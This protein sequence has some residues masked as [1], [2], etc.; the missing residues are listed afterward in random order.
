MLINSI[1]RASLSVVEILPTPIGIIATSTGN[2][3]SAKSMTES[4]T[5]GIVA[6]AGTVPDFSGLVPGL[7]YYTNTMGQMMTVGSAYSGRVC[8]ASPNADEYYYIFDEDSNTIVSLDSQVGVASSSSS[9]L[10]Q[11]KQ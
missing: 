7:K 4:S 8:S 5:E 9:I 2:T 10:I 1:L 6:L 3:R 11:L